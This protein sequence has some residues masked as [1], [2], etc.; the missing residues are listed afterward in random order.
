MGQAG[1]KAGA[2]AKKKGVGKAAA[3]LFEQSTRGNDGDED[4]D[5]DVEVYDEFLDGADDS[6]KVSTLASKGQTQKQQQEVIDAF[7]KGSVNVLVATCIGEE[8]L[9]IGSVDLVVFY[10]S[11]A[12]PIR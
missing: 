4:E 1:P 6:G 9:D 8:G 5:E 10:D 3:S 12:S 7:R 2:S 11:V